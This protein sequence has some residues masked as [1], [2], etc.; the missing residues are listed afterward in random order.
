MTSGKTD[1][2]AGQLPVPLYPAVTSTKEKDSP[3]IHREGG[4]ENGSTRIDFTENDQSTNRTLR[5]EQRENSF[6]CAQ[7]SR[8]FGTLQGLRVH[9]GRT[10][11]KKSRQ[12]RSTD[13]K[14][15]SKSSQDE[16]H[17]GSIN[18]SVDSPSSQVQSD[19]DQQAQES[20]ARRPRI[21]WPAANQKEKYKALEEKAKERFKEKQKNASSWD[22]KELLSVF[23]DAIYETAVEEFGCGEGKKKPQ[24]KK[25]GLSRRQR[26]LAQ[27][28][29]QKRDLR[30]QRKD[31]PPEEEEGLKTLFEDLKKRSR[32]V[33][34]QERRCTRRKEGKREREQFLKNPYEA[35]KKLFTEARS[36]KLK[37]TK[38]ELDNHVKQTYSDPRRNEP[39]PDM[40]GL[41]YPSAPGVTFQLG[42]ITEKEVDDFVKKA[43]AKSAPGGDGVSY[44]V[45]KY[46]KKLRNL[47]FQL[48]RSLWDDKE[49]VEEWC[50]AEGVY[51]PKEQNA[52]NIGQF[53]PISIIN[54]AC[55]IFMGILAKRT[56]AYLQSNGYVDES[57][58]KAGIPG[59]PG[60][61]EHAFTLWD[62]I[63]EAKKNKE[64]LNVVWLDL[65]NA[66]GSVPHELLM[67]AMD[68]FYIPPEVQGIMKKYYGNFQMRFS[69]EDFTT[70]WHRLEIG[71]AAGCT[72]SVI[73]FI[74][75]MEMI[76]R[77]TDFSE[78]EA[79]VRAPKKAFMDDITLLTRDADT[80]QCVLSRLDELITWSRMKFKAQKSRSLTF[81]KGRQTQRKFKIAGE[82]MPTVKD[83]PVKSLGRW[84]AGSLS[85]KSRGVAIEKQAEDGLK[86]ID[87]TKLPGKHKIWCLQ[88]ALY[89]RLAWPLTMYEVAVSRVEKIEQ[90]CNTY[91][92][93]WLGLPGMINTSS[94][95]RQKGALQLPL[96]SIVEIYKAGKVRTVMML[97]ESKDQ[98][99]SGNP[100]DVR[101]ARK[102]QAEVATDEIIS[103]LE[104]RDMIGATQTDR[105]G[106]GN[107]DFRP[108]KQM[109]QRDRRIA[110]AGK[111]RQMEAEKR[112]LHLIQC[113]QQGQVTSWEGHVVE[114]K[115]GWSEVWKWNTS[116][117]SFLLRATYDVLPSP[118]NLVR[119]KIQKDD[120]CRCGKLGT[121]KH[122]LSNCHLAL[123]RYTWRH[124]KV[125]S[126]FTEVARKQVGEGMYAPKLQRPGQ[127]KIEFVPQGGKVPDRKKANE[128][129]VRP[130]LGRWEVAADLQGSERFFPIPTT[131]KPDLVIWCEEEKEVHIV[132]LTVPY[133]DNI[134]S[135]HERKEKRYE[136]LVEDCV[137]AGWKA[138]HFP[139]EVGCRGFIATSVRKWMR[140][141]GLGPKK[142][143]AMT[144]TLQDTVEKASHWVW[145]KR[146]DNNW[147][148]S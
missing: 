139:V 49:L 73:W 92:R 148:E 95:Y 114:R 127:S 21:L 44:K 124:N 133:E 41:K 67:K 123:D 125:L 90:K 142:A 45:F 103:T 9:Q 120:K 116:R 31:A 86:A 94:L 110:A 91:I 147:C 40:R 4:V 79:K 126:V 68:F 5:R 80:M 30:R 52:E 61:T 87:K 64:N 144:K 97:R 54:V 88:F 62:A 136:A 19:A 78:E 33:Q 122:V 129:S 29:K 23:A 56:V 72:I 20:S 59:I 134:S 85:D 13:R 130:S 132:E 22:A 109:S 3:R 60:C 76:L 89:P 32:D 111:V 146:E 27:L 71:I 119:W 145:L 128:S 42:P 38:E 10:C 100:P 141:A 15:R 63:Q 25:G 93:K 17:S 117:L 131:K 99:I 14:T 50:R 112:E 24:E 11:M 35:A 107:G 18:V 46:C 98:E 7:C 48:L 58:Q 84:Y 28:R 6:D 108:F 104:H 53:R 43:R 2:D 140:E 83:E 70:E 102:W 113:A 65:A 8:S 81:Q 118:V 82:E 121:M 105:L 101:T 36:G 106:L 26:L 115:I 77:S 138:V 143:S 37:C 137:E 75:V 39:L 47:L 57:V 96:A 51:L 16:N 55:K 12:C 66:Y 69:T 74:L 1:G 34:R 135:A